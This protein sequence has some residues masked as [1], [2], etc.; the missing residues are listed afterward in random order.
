[1]SVFIDYTVYKIAIFWRVTLLLYIAHVLPISVSRTP[2]TDLESRVRFKI[3]E[4]SR[5]SRK[6]DS[7]RTAPRVAKLS[8]ED[9]HVTWSGIATSKARQDLKNPCKYDNTVN[10]S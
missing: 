8:F 10:D 4:D 7:V 6:F 5:S 9:Y 3:P 2:H 1:M